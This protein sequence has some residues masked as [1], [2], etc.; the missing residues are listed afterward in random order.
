LTKK[1]YIFAMSLFKAVYPTTFNL[2]ISL[3][4]I[5]NKF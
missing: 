1:K 2:S 3:R 5:L 4:M